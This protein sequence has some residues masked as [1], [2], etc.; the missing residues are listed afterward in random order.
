M[1]SIE[2]L[3]LL[4]EQNNRSD[5]YSILEQYKEGTLDMYLSSSTELDLGTHKATYKNVKSSNLS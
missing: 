4:V 3:S 2:L 5:I 1:V